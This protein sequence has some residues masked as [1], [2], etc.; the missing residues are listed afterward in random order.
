MAQLNAS[1]EDD[2]LLSFLAF[3][4]FFFQKNVFLI[5]VISPTN[6]VNESVRVKEEEEEEGER[7]RGRRRRL[8]FF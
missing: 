3:P 4:S 1:L 6:G 2:S 7:K 5:S 8:G